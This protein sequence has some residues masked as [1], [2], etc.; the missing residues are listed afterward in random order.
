MGYTALTVHAREAHITIPRHWIKDCLYFS[1]VDQQNC[2]CT[3]AKI[4]QQDQIRYKPTLNLIAS[5]FMAYFLF[6]LANHEASLLSITLSILTLSS[7][8]FFTICA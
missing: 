6:V 5:I 7:N 4:I 1:T 8:S 2:D 3:I